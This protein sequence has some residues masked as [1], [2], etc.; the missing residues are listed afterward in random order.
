VT[1]A[2][3]CEAEWLLGPVAA[4][5]HPP[6]VAEL[7]RS[8]RDWVRRWNADPRPFVWNKTADEILDTLAAYCQRISNSGH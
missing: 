2:H 5:R 3:P 8:I 4:A 7:E 1:V 6:R